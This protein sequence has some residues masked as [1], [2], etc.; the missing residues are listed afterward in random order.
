MLHI[1]NHQ[2]LGDSLMATPALKKLSEMGV[3]YT[4]YF[5]NEGIMNIYRNVG[6]MKNKKWGEMPPDPL[7]YSDRVIKLESGLALNHAMST[8]QHYAFGF[9]EQLGVRINN[10]TPDI[11]FNNWPAQV[12]NTEGTVF[13][14]PESSS[15][16]SGTGGK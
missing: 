12:M 5:L 15:C 4:C 16:A 1:I 6:W 2:L 11:D 10:P 3:D 9:A 7:P 8:G 14:F 13:V